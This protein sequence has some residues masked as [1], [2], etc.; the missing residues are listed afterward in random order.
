MSMINYW[1]TL[2]LGIGWALASS[3][4]CKAQQACG[5]SDGAEN[6]SL[7]DLSPAFNMGF[8]DPIAEDGKGGW[9]DQGP[10]N[11]MAVLPIGKQDFCGVP[12][13]VANPEKNDGRACLV[14]QGKPRP[15]F[16]LETPPLPV[17]EKGQI[18]YFLGTCAWN[19]AVGEE[20]LRLVVTYRNDTRYSE[21]AFVYG[22]DLGAWWA[23]SSP[24]LGQLAWE[25]SNSSSVLGLYLF[26]WINPYPDR[27]ID[28]IRLVSAN[29]S[30]VPVVVAATL[31]KESEKSSKIVAEL[32]CKEEALAAV[33]G[34]K[35]E[36]AKLKIDFFQPGKPIPGKLF[37]VANGEAMHPDFEAPAR[38]LFSRGGERPFYRYQLNRVDPSIAKGV[39]DFS[40]LDEIVD[41]AVAYGAE[42]ML[43]IWAPPKWMYEKMSSYKE[44]MKLRRPED[45][46]AFAD[47]CAEIVRHYNVTRK[48]NG[49]EPVIWWEIGNEMELY[50][51]SYGYYIKVYK[52]VARKMRAVDPSI[53]IGGPVTAGP[54]YGWAKQLLTTLPGEVDFVSY[55]EYGYSEPFSTPDAYIMGR[56]GMFQSCAKQY[57]QMMEEVEPGR[58]IP[59]MLTE[60]NTSWR[61]HEGT[62]PRIRTQF[63]AA[64]LASV[65]G[66]FMEGGGTS[67]CYFTLSGGFGMIWM[68]K[69]QL[70]VYPNYYAMWLYR[71]FFAGTAIPVASDEESVEAY[72]YRSDQSMGVIVINKND[73]K[74]QVSLKA[75]GGG[76]GAPQC[77]I[78]NDST[79]P[80]MQEFK[81]GEAKD[82][83]TIA[84]KIPEKENTWKFDMEPYEVRALIWNK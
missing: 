13:L 18:I 67:F 6:Y 71:N 24:S 84:Q 29:T 4:K 53:K 47:Y 82:P 11:D 62:D 8:A 22:K 74:I 76:K 20:V 48:A 16:L 3:P 81:V 23:P 63:C 50:E 75:N 42:P 58:K 38:E 39:W 73:G 83:E 43:C 32:R 21:S 1:T 35:V 27:E 60:S 68:E 14:F 49:K 36:R 70:K 17:R 2:L 19:A 28:T 78:V 9:T 80:S 66:H 30:A 37:S 77:Y 44:S 59:L 10:A 72:G 40:R 65:M 33:S 51:W 15:H 41:T 45:I 79:M 34:H 46:G 57:R 31:L 55:H 5:E 54:N 69:G 7:I 64:W 52:E 12:F 61:Y 26:A 56:T 25:G